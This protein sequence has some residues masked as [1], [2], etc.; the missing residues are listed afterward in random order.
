MNEESFIGKI[1]C[2]VALATALGWILH[3]T[4]GSLLVY[5]T[6]TEFQIYWAETVAACTGIILG[7]VLGWR[8]SEIIITSTIFVTLH[9]VLFG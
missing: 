8:N 2:A 7:A 1:L 3:I 9:N 4:V 5:S 6:A